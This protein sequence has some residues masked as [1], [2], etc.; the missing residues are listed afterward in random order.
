VEPDRRRR[1]AREMLATID[2]IPVGPDGRGD[3]DVHDLVAAMK[4]ETDFVSQS[5]ALMRWSALTGSRRCS[6]RLWSLS[7]GGDT[8][9]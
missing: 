4:L 3:F 1:I 6:T 2:A 7:V 8:S 9:R 5:S